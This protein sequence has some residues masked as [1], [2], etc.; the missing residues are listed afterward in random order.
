M[1]NP[2]INR[3]NPDR[4]KQDIAQSVDLYNSWFMEFAPKAFRETRLLTAAR[5]EQALAATN[6]LI[7]VSI[8]LLK[9]HP[10]VLPILRMSTC[11]PIARDRLVGLARVSKNLVECMED[12]NPRIPPRISAERLYNDLERISGIIEK[13]ADPDI[14]VWLNRAESASDIEINRAATIVADRLCGAISDP[15]IRNAQEK[16]QL[17]AIGGWL[18][19][20]G[21]RH[22]EGIT[23]R[24]MEPG[25]YSFRANVPVCIAGDGEPAKVNIPVDVVIIPMQAKKG[26][27]PLLIEAKS[28]GDFTNVNK[29]RKEEAQKMTQLK[30]TYGADVRFGL[31]LCGY[32]DS[33][34]LGYE[35]AEGIDWVWE[36][37]IDDLTLFGL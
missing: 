16:R 1:K 13:M 28:A 23:F 35:A 9:E 11:P 6:N 3:S 33:G 20:R 36:H 17:N 27:I 21:Y 5:V 32:F 8:E 37:R 19:A 12:S 15:I 31:F 2:T 29:R 4:W 14:F 7:D 24:E 34:Y 18:Q 25:T 26:D 22:S 30:G 10:E